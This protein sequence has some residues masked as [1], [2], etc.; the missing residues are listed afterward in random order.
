MKRSDQHDLLRELFEGDALSDF[1]RAS[2]EGGLAAIRQQRRRRRALRVSALAALPMLLALAMVLHR[3]PE[4]AKPRT[5]PNASRA[6]TT[7]VKFITDEEL[8]ALFPDRPMALIG[9]PGQQ[10]LVFLDTVIR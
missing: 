9:K 1:R 7:K 6:E 3:G 2:L 5:V 10:R 8:F 4:S